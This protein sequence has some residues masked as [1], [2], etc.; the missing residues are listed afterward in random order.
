MNKKRK[1]DPCNPD[2][3]I[4]KQPLHVILN[5]FVEELPSGC[6]C[7]P[8]QETITRIKVTMTALIVW[9]SDAPISDD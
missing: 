8:S 2:C 7:N 3:I 9:S 1:Q 5:E 4:P 6:F